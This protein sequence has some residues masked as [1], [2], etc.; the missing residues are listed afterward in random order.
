MSR[1]E[2]RQLRHFVAVA[3]ELHFARAG[4]RLGME[5]PPLSHS[6]R[7]LDGDLA[8]ELKAGFRLSPVGVR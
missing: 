3:E 7:T 1:V 8:V 2:L 6:I 5:Q 4:E